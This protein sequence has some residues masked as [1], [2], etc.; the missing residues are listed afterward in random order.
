M[1]T[2]LFSLLPLSAYAQWDLFP[3]ECLDFDGYNDYVRVYSTPELRPANNFTIEAWVCRDNYAHERLVM[4]DD[5]G[6]GDDGYV[7]GLHSDGTAFFAAYNSNGAEAQTIYS[8]VLVPV[9]EWTHVAG[10]YD[11]STLKIYVNGIEK[12]RATSGDVAYSIDFY[13]NIGRR[14]GTYAPNTGLF[15]GRMEEIRFWNTTRTAMEIRWYMH[16]TCGYVSAYPVA[17]WQCNLGSDP[18]ILCSPSKHLGHF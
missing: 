10:V 8:D 9:G 1:I 14:G 12:T 4:H 18:D 6:G 16:M 13:L 15:D 3:G 11:N 5:D 17:Q 2:L 7:L